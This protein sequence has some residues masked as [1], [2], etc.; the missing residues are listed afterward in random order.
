MDGNK[1]STSLSCSTSK[2]AADAITQLVVAGLLSAGSG[3]FSV[4]ASDEMRASVGGQPAAEMEVVSLDMV[5]G[6]C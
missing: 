5:E 4:S 1:G 2:G 3:S 6:E